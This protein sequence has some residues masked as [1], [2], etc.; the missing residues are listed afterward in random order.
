M[1]ATFYE[2]SEVV[3]VAEFST[4]ADVLNVRIDDIGSRLSDAL[5]ARQQ[6]M[7]KNG[8]RVRFGDNEAVKI[9]I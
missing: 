2:N 1:K 6:T 7:L 5:T 3:E 8:K 4:V 9:D